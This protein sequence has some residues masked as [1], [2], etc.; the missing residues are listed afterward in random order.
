MKNAILSPYLRAQNLHLNTFKP[1]KTE[2]N[3]GFGV[4]IQFLCYRKVCLHDK[5]RS[6]HAV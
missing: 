4:K 6:V 5:G 2:I 3:F 1:M